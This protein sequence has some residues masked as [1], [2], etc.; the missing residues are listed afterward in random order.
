M[1]IVQVST[2]TRSLANTESNVCGSCDDAVGGF[3]LKHI[4]KWMKSVASRDLFHMT[5]CV[6]SYWTAGSSLDINLLTDP[7]IHELMMVIVA[8][9]PTLD[10]KK[11]T[12]RDAILECHKEKPC[13]FH[14]GTAFSVA[15]TVAE[16]IRKV[17]GKY[18]FM[19]NNAHR[20]RQTCTRATHPEQKAASLRCYPRWTNI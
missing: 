16:R 9:D 19:R 17:T 12:L 8:V 13:L 5:S 2:E 15:T 20:F 7:Y 11:S 14:L 10:P 4:Q 3:G 18:R 1:A 6:E